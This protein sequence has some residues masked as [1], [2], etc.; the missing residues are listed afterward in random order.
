M[1]NWIGGILHELFP[2]ILIG[3]LPPDGAAVG[4]ILEGVKNLFDCSDIP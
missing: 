4:S 1:T 2:G 3:I